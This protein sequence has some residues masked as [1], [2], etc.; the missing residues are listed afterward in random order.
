M[1]TAKRMFLLIGFVLSLILLLT[2]G[3]GMAQDI[4]WKVANQTTM[5]WNPVTTVKDLNGNLV[6][7]PAG[8][9]VSY[10]LYAFSPPSARPDK[11]ATPLNIIAPV[12]YVFTF[13]AE[14]RYIMGVNS[15]RYDNSTTPPTLLSTSIISWSDDPAVC[16]G[17]QTFGVMFYYLPSEPGGLH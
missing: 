11:T 4:N 13:I 6:P 3:S 7:I 1:K 5:S 10:G 8:Q 14:G 2:L 17:G 12:S 15:V 16:A 9:S